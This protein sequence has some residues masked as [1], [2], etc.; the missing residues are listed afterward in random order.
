MRLSRPGPLLPPTTLP[1]RWP[2]RLSL[3]PI[4]YFEGVWEPSLPATSYHAAASEISPMTDNFLRKLAEECVSASYRSTDAEA[5]S[6][7]L[8][9]ATEL[10]KHAGEPAKP[11]DGKLIALWHDLDGAEGDKH[12]NHSE[13]NKERATH[14][15][16]NS[17]FCGA[18][19]PAP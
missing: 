19:R 2:G 13:Q 11:L 18:R 14:G 7:L 5:A 15:F 10:L 16:N 9:I 1:V 12:R 17:R 8:G 6:K 4:Q 3:D